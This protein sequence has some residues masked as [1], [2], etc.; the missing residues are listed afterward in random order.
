MKGTLGLIGAGV[1]LLA[2]AAPVIQTAPTPG[3]V[4]A[5]AGLFLIAIAAWR[6]K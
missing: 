5:L 4:I 3:L 2:I 6:I 1:A